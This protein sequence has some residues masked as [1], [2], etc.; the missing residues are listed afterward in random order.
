[1][2]VSRE[3]AVHNRNV[4]VDAASRL[5]RR[6]GFD[7]VSISEI[8]LESGLTHGGFYKQFGSK[9]DLAAQACA[10]ALERSRERWQGVV[11][12]AALGH[13][14]AAVARDYLSARNRDLPETGCALAAS[15]ADAARRGGALATASTTGM[16]GLTDILTDTSGDRALALAQLSQMVGA[17]VLARAVDDATLSDEIMAAAYEALTA[18]PPGTA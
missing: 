11:R 10:R 12:D 3:R 18:G 17:M 16:N 6:F 13:E 9:E 2:K 1:M 4:V 8:M 5:F 14:I 7:G 15:G